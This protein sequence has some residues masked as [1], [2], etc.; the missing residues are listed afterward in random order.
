MRDQMLTMVASIP[1]KAGQSVPPLWDCALQRDEKSRGLSPK[2]S[3]GTRDG[4]R[5]TQARKVHQ[6]RHAGRRQGACRPQRRCRKPTDAGA[7]CI[8]TTRL[9]ACAPERF[10]TRDH[11]R[12]AIRCSPCL[13][14]SPARRQTPAECHRIPW[15][16]AMAPHSAASRRPPSWLRMMDIRPGGD[17]QNLYPIL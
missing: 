16:R 7:I 3:F 4:G 8:S 2:L 6:L 14:R 10:I 13:G 9:Q 17:R 15:N 5:G 12:R 11:C 1:S